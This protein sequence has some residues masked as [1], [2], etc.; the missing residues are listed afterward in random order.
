MDIKAVIFDMDGVIVN[1]EPEYQR[2]ELE[3]MKRFHIPYDESDLRRF[4]G[5]NSVLMWRE[6]KEKFPELEFT[7]EEIYEHEARMMREHYR[8]DQLLTIK[9]ALKLIN[10]VFESGYK[11]AVASSSDRENVHHVLERLNIGQYF[12]A[13]VTNDDVTRCKPSPDIYFLAA[14]L[15]GVEAREALVI[16]DSMAGVAAARAAGMRV[17]W[18]TSEHASHED[19]SVFIVSDLTAVSIPVLIN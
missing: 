19:D 17:I 11:M 18:Y 6:I 1:S 13:I 14:R 3:L 2:I 5:V 10:H 9:P 4:T 8:S 12:S 7:A 16:E 15:L